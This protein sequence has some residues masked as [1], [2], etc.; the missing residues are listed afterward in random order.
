M[1]NSSKIVKL[2]GKNLNKIY[3]NKSVEAS[4]RIAKAV[5]EFLSLYGEGEF[6]VFSVSGRSEICGNHTDHNLGEVAAASVDLDII[7]VARAVKGSVIRVK[8]EGFDED[9]VDTK[10]LKPV[11]EESGT[12]ASLIR[13][14]I[15]GLKKNKRKTGSFVAYTTNQI[16]KGSGLSS[17]AAFEDMIG[18]IENYI[19]NEGKIGF[20]EIAQLGQYAENKFFGKPCGLMDQIACA[21]GGFVHI[22]FKDPSNPKTEKVKFDPEQH[23][24][25]LYIV[26]TGGSHVNLTPDYASVPSEMKAVA[27]L[28]GQKTLRG[29]TEKMLVSKTNEIRSK[30]GDRAMLRAIHFVREN[31]RVRDL[32]KALRKDDIEGFL[33]VVRESGNSSATLLQNC[34]SVTDVKEQGIPLACAVAESV[35]GEKGAFRVHGGGF[36][37]T[38]Q[39]Y[40]PLEKEKLFVK[41]I[42]E[43]F[44][45]EAVTILR[46]RPYGAV[47]VF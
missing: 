34:Y 22:D 8:S 45:K 9:V 17:S 7:A 25:A 12:S 18:T 40:V 6:S 4:K 16:K 5:N 28:F 46:I 47:K 24:Y 41:K 35:V 23:G 15:D 29:I 43:S 14:V 42:S 39:A 33:S 38:I 30:L 37:G 44:G 1:Y 13:G 3:G 36:A 11:P 20:T 26:D 32:F 10:N 2:S 27:G 21:A 31:E 19:Y